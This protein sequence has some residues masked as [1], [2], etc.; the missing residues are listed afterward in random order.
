MTVQR[1][2]AREITLERA[3]SHV[4]E[5]CAEALAGTAST[6][7]DWLLVEQP[8]AWG[9]DAVTHSD[10]PIDV[11]LRLRQQAD[12]VAARLLLIRR[13]GRY[14]GT[15]PRSVYL[16]HSGPDAPW[17]RRLDFL[18]PRELLDLDVAA[19]FANPAGRS[20]DPLYAVCANG[21]HDVCCALAGIP[22]ARAIAGLGDV[23]HCSHV[24]GDRF[25]G[26]LVCFPE[27][28]YYGRVSPET[29]AEI[30]AAHRRGELV[31]PHLRGR[32]CQ[33][34]A[35]QAGEHFVRVERGLTALGAVRLLGHY[36][37]GEGL[38]C[39]FA[40]PAG[41]RVAVEVRTQRALQPR[42]LTCHGVAT[43]P[44]VYDVR[45]A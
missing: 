31:L 17:Q 2:R 18:H 19:D 6:V 38:R 41:E 20:T 36:S 33:P 8:G 24:G 27:G 12:A 16:I 10:L 40:L 15:H 25:A 34:F 30:V 11:G 26:N 39:A 14:R 3:C 4:S 9:Q 29:G 42:R 22:L 21:K 37:T 23:W 1:R 13:P 28:L 32:S 45:W 7:T 44:P 35:V 5:L 43:S